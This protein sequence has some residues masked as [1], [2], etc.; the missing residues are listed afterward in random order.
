MAYFALLRRRNCRFLMAFHYECG[1]CVAHIS[2]V[3]MP[4]RLSN[5][6][7]STFPLAR[8]DRK[9]SFC[10]STIFIRRICNGIVFDGKKASDF[11]HRRK[12]QHFTAIQNE[13][14]WPIHAIPI[15]LHSSR[16]WFE[17]EEKRSQQ[18]TAKNNM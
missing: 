11:Q 1:E 18:Q 3:R 15:D 16:I 9:R 10:A 8:E 6:F 14:A 4:F 12:N 17:T 5:N 7:W 2:G 13:N